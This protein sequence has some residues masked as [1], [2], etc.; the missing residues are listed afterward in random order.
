[1]SNKSNKNQ[2]EYKTE[3]DNI[4]QMMLSYND[5][6]IQ[7]KSI[8]NDT[9]SIKNEEDINKINNNLPIIAVMGESKCGKSFVIQKMLNSD[10]ALNNSDV[11]FCEVSSNLELNIFKQ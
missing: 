8:I 7:S 5:N 11:K 1:M 2:D 9:I 3:I 6:S 4:F 10:C